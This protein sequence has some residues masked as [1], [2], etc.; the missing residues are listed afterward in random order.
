MEEDC[1][2]ELKQLEDN[3]GDDR[4]GKEHE[5]S[6]RQTALTESCVFLPYINN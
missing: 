2:R 5:R 4:R 3:H 1:P 6:G